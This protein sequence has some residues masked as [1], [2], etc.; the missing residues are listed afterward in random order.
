MYNLVN[1]YVCMLARSAAFR[2]AVYTP[3]IGATN[4]A[5]EARIEPLSNSHVGFDFC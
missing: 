5:I 2:S 4:A 3:P 1:K